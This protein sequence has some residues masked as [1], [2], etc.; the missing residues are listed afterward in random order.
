VSVFVDY[1]FVS[2]GVIGDKVS[3]FPI[4]ST[5]W[6]GRLPPLFDVRVLCINA[7]VKDSN[8]YWWNVLIVAFIIDMIAE[9]LEG[10]NPLGGRDVAAMK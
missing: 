5:S 6:F 7:C 3:I 9:C 8:F 10:G 4:P 1:L 2:I